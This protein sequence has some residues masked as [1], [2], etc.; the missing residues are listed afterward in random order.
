MRKA[1]KRCDFERE[2]YGAPGLEPFEMGGE[3]TKARMESVRG[4]ERGVR[5][6]QGRYLVLVGLEVVEGSFEGGVLV[7]G[8]L[9][10]HDGQRQTI[11]EQHHIGAAVVTV[12]DH[13]LRGTLASEG[14]G[15]PL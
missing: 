1:G 9:Q 15:N 14:R 13:E 3:R 2:G 11:D 6:E 7:A 8:V 5:A 4:H 10:L 12:L